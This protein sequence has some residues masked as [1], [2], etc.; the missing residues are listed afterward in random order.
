MSKIRIEVDEEKLVNALDGFIGAGGVRDLIKDMFNHS[1]SAKE[2]LGQLLLGENLPMKPKIGQMGLFKI[3]GQWFTNK[4]TTKDT[5]LDLKGYVSCRVTG[6]SAYTDYS[7]IKVELPTY[8]ESGAIAVISTGL[9][10]DE[11]IWLEEDKTILAEF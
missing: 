11:F 10:Y 5:D 9:D 1:Q 8:N 7:P 3:S 6:L 2:I 4:D